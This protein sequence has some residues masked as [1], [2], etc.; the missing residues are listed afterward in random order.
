MSLDLGLALMQRNPSVEPIG[1]CPGK[2]SGRPQ[3]WW[4]RGFT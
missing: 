2:A 4:L 3:P 1:S